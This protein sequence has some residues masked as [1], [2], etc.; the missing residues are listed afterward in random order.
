MN[1]SAERYADTPPPPPQAVSPPP[2]AS[3]V[4]AASPL[5]NRVKSATVAFV[6][7]A[8]PGLG[9][10][11]VGYYQRGFLHAIVVALI[12]AMLASADV[13]P[14][15]PLLGLFL[16]F[17]W[18]FNMIDAARRASL[19]NQALAGGQEPELPVDFETPGLR[20]SI[21]GGVVLMIIG[22]ILL[23]NTRFDVSLDWLEEWWPAAIILFGAYL[24]FKA[25]QERAS[26]GEVAESDE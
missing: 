17:F 14:L 11:Y 2:A 16:A 10:V 15:T 6:L 9:Q 1:E 13:G 26:E 25:M 7:S 5:D 12:I 3:T 8:M 23:A 24:L 22:A 4:Q 19:Y 20:G 21:V 18:L